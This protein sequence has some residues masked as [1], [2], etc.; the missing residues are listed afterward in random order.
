MPCSQIHS[1]AD[2][3]FA[4]LKAIHPNAAKVYG[5]L[6]PSL[7]YTGSAYYSL[8]GIARETG[9]SLATVKRLLRLLRSGCAIDW[10]ISQN[11]HRWEANE[12]FF[13][14]SAWERVQ[15]ALN[16]ALVGA[17]DTPRLA[18]VVVNWAAS[19][20]PKLKLLLAPLRGGALAGLVAA[21]SGIAP[22]VILFEGDGRPEGAA[23][24]DTGKLVSAV[25]GVL[26]LGGCLEVHSGDTS[27]YLKRYAARPNVALY[28]ARQAVKPGSDSS[29][30]FRLAARHKGPWLM[31]QEDSPKIRALATKYGFEIEP[32]PLK[33]LK[34]MHQDLLVARKGVIPTGPAVL[35]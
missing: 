16:A 7:A 9:L 4:L 25:A 34:A 30:L 13:P 18:P 6:T 14:I 1:S 20:R 21:L 32:L 29:G 27:R 22:K 23:L 2:R 15:S 10:K 3:T 19:L 5:F 26:E 28:L 12:Y 24:S 17:G 33:G 11:W 35:Q 31:S 8:N